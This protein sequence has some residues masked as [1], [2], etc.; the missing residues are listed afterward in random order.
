MATRTWGTIEDV[1]RLGAKGERYELIDGELVPMSPTGS[2]HGNIEMFAGTVLNNYVLPR[3]LG[4]VLGGEVLFRLDPAERLALA[5][6]IAFVRRERWLAQPS[7]SGAFVGPPDLAVE[8]VS[9]GDSAQEIQDKVEDWL[10]HGAIAVLLMFPDPPAAVL[11]TAQGGTSLR[12]D[13]ELD[14]D[15][16]LPGFRCQIRELFPPPM[17]EP[18]AG[19]ERQ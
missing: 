4:R 11:W 18:T 12:G 10:E 2:E 16:V 13:D 8:I 6:D 1:L 15:P 9:P 3:H 14:L 17:E 19:T 7:H 5:P